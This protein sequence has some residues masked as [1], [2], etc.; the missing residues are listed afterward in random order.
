MATELISKLTA[1]D[2]IAPVLLAQLQSGEL[3]L[4]V[5]GEVKMLF[6][7]LAEIIKKGIK[8]KMTSENIEYES[9]EN[10]ELKLQNSR[11][12]DYTNNKSWSL[13][14]EE[15]KMLKEAQKSIEKEIREVT[16]DAVTIE[17]RLVISKKK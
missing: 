9:N 3:P 15:I 13:L 7:N 16:G 14:D 2:E 10:V 12:Y 17:K 8:S 1:I 5:A 11:K 4:T 6:E